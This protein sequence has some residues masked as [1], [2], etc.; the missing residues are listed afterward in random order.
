MNTASPIE[1]ASNPKVEHN[2]RAFL[3]G[4][5]SAE[6]TPL[7]QLS[8]KEARDRLVH[9]QARAPHDLP[10]ATIDQKTVEAD[11]LS[12]NL[13]IVRPIGVKEKGPAFLFFHRGDFMLGDFPTHE[14]LVRD[15]V[16]DSGFTSIFV[17]YTRS[18]EAQYPTAINEAYAATM[19]GSARGRDQRGR[20]TPGRGRQ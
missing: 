16:S 19:G 14:H 13:T 11:G 1:P 9:L 2:T 20:Q 10:P 6:G 7:E 15:L 4:L 17:N 12:V 3:K 18:P 5:N 8:P